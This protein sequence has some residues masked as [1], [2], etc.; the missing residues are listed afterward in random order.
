MRT[1][2]PFRSEHY[3]AF[4]RRHA[5]CLGWSAPDAPFPEAWGGSEDGQ[6]WETIAHHVRQGAGAGVGIKPSDYRTV[7]LT[8][9]EHREL[10]Q[11]G[12]RAFWQAHGVDPAAIILTLLCR[13][14][15]AVM[16]DGPVE[17]AIAVLERQADAMAWSRRI[18]KLPRQEWEAS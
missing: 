12:E 11:M 17:S 2:T 13:Y 9:A 7:P 16:P 15:G 3:L 5:T 14:T 4:V 18:G 8:D 1:A 6:W 10:H